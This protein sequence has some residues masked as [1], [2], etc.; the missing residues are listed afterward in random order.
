MRFSLVKGS[1]FFVACWRCGARHWAGDTIPGVTPADNQPMYQTVYVVGSEPVHQ[2]T[3]YP[4]K[5]A[6]EAA[7]T[8]VGR[9]SE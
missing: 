7:E 1:P 8:A 5:L 6:I 3:C 4:C 9:A 2:F